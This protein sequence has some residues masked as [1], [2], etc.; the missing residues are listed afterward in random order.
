VQLVAVKVCSSVSSSCN[1]IALLKGMDYALDPDGN[2]AT[3]D[4]VDVINLSLGS[5][6]G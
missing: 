1:G 5:S 2:P 4:G 3:D 6:Y